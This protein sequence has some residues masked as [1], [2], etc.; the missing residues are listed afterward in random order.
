LFRKFS[1][2]FAETHRSGHIELSPEAQQLISQ[3][4][5]PGNVRQLKNVTEQI[6]VLEDAGTLSAETVSKYLPPAEPSLPVLLG[7]SE[8]FGEGMSE[9]DIFYK[10]L[11]DLKRDVTDLKKLVF[12]MLDN[13]VPA[14]PVN[15]QTPS[16]IQNTPQL[17]IPTA[18]EAQPAKP[19]H[20]GSDGGVMLQPNDENPIEIEHEYVEAVSYPVSDDNLSLEEKELEMIRRALTKSKGRRKKA[21][22][23]L[24]ISERTLYR[25]IKQ[26]E[27][28]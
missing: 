5:W 11:I 1:S 26:Y 3:Y 12:G 4:S 13:P 19:L 28:E 14:A 21:A 20:A 15:L 10:V 25:K 16:P 22:E 17:Q 18:I 24:G 6:C 8:G 7:K 2:D 27:L 23:A 9:R